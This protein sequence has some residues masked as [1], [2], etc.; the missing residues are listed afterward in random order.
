MNFRSSIFSRLCSACL[1]AAILA[2]VPLAAAQHST[3]PDSSA[4]RL[5]DVALSETGVLHARVVDLQG[6]P[7]PGETVTI[8]HNGREIATTTSDAEGIAAVSGLRPGIHTI[9][10]PM[11]AVVCRFWNSDSAPPASVRLPAVVSD[12]DIVRGQF[13]AFNLPMLVYAG[14]SAAAL[15]I[16]LDA[17][18]DADDAKDAIRDLEDRLEALENASP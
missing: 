18:G 15:I 7:V 10:T 13:G 11:G 9:T 16:A 6:L 8:L 17:E 4:A 2:Q 1:A 5:T 3:P 12:A 14:V